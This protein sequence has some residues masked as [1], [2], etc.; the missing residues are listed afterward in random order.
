MNGMEAQQ[1]RKANL[2]RGEQCQGDG[3]VPETKFTAGHLSAGSVDEVE[4]TA[5]ARAG[6]QMQEQVQ[7]AG[8][9]IRSR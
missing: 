8:S 9:G 5:P 7:P 1:E 3:Q 2:R 4:H 6:G